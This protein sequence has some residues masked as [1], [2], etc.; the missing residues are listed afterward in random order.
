MKLFTVT[1][2][3]ELLAR[4]EPILLEIRDRYA[5]INSMRSSARLAAGASS[6]GG[7]M[8]GG[9]AYVQTLYEVGRLT[10]EIYQ[11]GVE[12][13]D[14]ERGLI[15]FPSM[16]GERIV[17]LCWQLGEPRQIEFWHEPDAGFSGRQRL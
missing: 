11:L 4:L 9:T 3:N 16:R 1:E 12:L 15:D 10:T 14:Y 6:A 8:R 13:K 17:L 7:G 5:R 2:A